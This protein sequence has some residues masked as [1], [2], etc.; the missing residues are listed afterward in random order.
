MLPAQDLTERGRHGLPP[1]PR[2]ADR[3]HPQVELDVIDEYGRPGQQIRGQFEL[4]RFVGPRV[5]MW[6]PGGT[7]G[8]PSRGSRDQVA[9]TMVDAAAA[10]CRGARRDF[11]CPAP[12]MAAITE[13]AGR[14][15][16]R[17]GS[18]WQNVSDLSWSRRP[19]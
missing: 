17:G 14:R 11:P 18:R 10:T 5:V 9:V 15:L 1:Q 7:F 12:D 3:P 16:C 4:A 19:D 13:A 8:G 2:V 6:P